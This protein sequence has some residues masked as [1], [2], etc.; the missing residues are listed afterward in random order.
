M[1]FRLQLIANSALLFV[2]IASIASG[3]QN[4][5][6]K[7]PYIDGAWWQVAGNPDLGKYTTEK[8][9]PVDFA[10]WQAA[11]G[12]WQL[13]S[14]IRHT[15]CEGK[16][17]LFHGWE[18]KSITDKDW[19]PLGVMMQADT[20]YGETA[21]GLQ[22][23]H[24]VKHDDTYYML[25]GDW[26][27]IC[28][29]TSKDGKKFERYVPAGG[30]TALF[31]EGLRTNTRDIVALKI[32]D[33]WHGYYT[34]YPSRQGAV[35]CRTS[36]DLK[37]WSE[38]TNV[39]FGGRAGVNPFAAECPHVVAHD[40]RYYLFRTQKYGQ[41][42]RSCV[43]TSTDPMN[44]GL[45]QD[46]RYFVTEMPVAAPEIVY[47]EGQHYMAALLPSLKGIQIAKL[48][49]T[50]PPKIDQPV[51]DFSS[52]DERD[53]WKVVQGGLSNIFTQSRRDRF[54]PPASHFIGTAESSGTSIN[55]KATCTIESP[56]FTIRT[57]WLFT[58]VSGGADRSKL[59]VALV[60]ADSK[61]ELARVA[62]AV[63]DNELIETAINVSSFVGR[64]AVVQ[65]VDESQST[66]GHINFGG[67]YTSK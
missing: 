18:G 38:S 58:Y 25:Y 37:N 54:S 62:P 34:A 29:A 30:K 40:G 52:P 60:D 14:C 6:V 33:I 32:G 24:V 1:R 64:K 61:Q 17:R 3:E 12:T 66:W 59:Y 11:D 13:W 49:W 57:P 19:R 22:A 16:T 4:A 2:A 26:E 36:R 43:Y 45:N 53:K 5:S 47:H 44:F 21:G 31:S 63:E 15:S 48:G 56:P 65:I 42:S 20:K 41:Q 27:N 10:V 55:D 50:E 9:Q 67:V 8:Q 39:A 35:Y 28:L 46:R 23:P 7:I 51:F